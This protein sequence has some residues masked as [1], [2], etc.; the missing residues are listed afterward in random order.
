VVNRPALVCEKVTVNYPG[1]PRPVLDQCSLRVEASE[2]V[3]LLGLNGSG[4]T[5]LLLAAVGLVPSSGRIVAAGRELCPQNLVA[6]RRSVGFLFSIPEDQLLLPRVVDDVALGVHP[7]Q[8]SRVE[9]LEQA[10]RM[11]EALGM[12]DLAG[13]EPGQL[14]HGQRLMAA[15]A[16]VLVGHPPLLLLDEP[17]NRLDPPSRLRLAD[18]LRRQSGALLVATHDLEFAARL[19]N[20]YV[21]L[22]GGRVIESGTDFGVVSSRWL[23][24][25]R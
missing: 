13:S 21:V 10:G 3:A 6:L 12:G 17:T 24:C 16:G 1:S 9:A 11:L 25:C 8:L 7:D 14:S 4:K 23:Q 20:R 2:R 22:E 5:T 18:L 19:C 15:L